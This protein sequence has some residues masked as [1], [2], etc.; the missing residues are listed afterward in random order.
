MPL[1]RSAYL[2]P[3][4]LPGGH[5]QTIYSARFVPQPEVQYRRERW[6][7]PDG[8]FIDVDFAAP[9]PAAADAPV[10]VL[11][12]GLEGCS[13]SHYA[14]A[15]MR[16]FADRGWRSMVAHFR[17][18]SGEPNRL[19]RAYHSGDSNE[20]DW[21][22][23]RAH[24]RWPQ[25]KLHAAGIS[26][27]GNMLA[28]WLGE[29]QEAASFVAAAASV[30]S[31]LD[32]AAGGAALARGFN[33]VYTKM[34][35][36]TLKNKALAKTQRFPGIAD[37]DALRASRNLYDFDNAFTAPVHGFRD[38]DDYWARASGKPWLPGVKVPHLVLNAR[39]DPF[40]PA[41]S[42]PREHEV[43]R[44]VVLEQ[45]EE[46]GHIGFAQGAPPGKLDFLPQR[47]FDFFARG[48]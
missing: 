15:I 42:L 13:R 16:H 43:S 1:I 19:P 31:P 2:A 45:P 32:L 46:G 3:R 25:A 38:A 47:L 12:H 4:W 9:E 30:G 24:A 6:D 40:V 7:T 22:L 29:R 17:G 14:L 18:C 21:V 36:A 41:A 34:F 20:G 37:P 33:L 26:L 39:N 5:A 10:L 44:H 27:G 11:F 28:K 35:L 23:R 48:A 8:D